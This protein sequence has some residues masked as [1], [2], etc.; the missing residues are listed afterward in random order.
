[1]SILQKSLPEYGHRYVVFRFL[2]QDENQEEFFHA[3][4][5][6]S[7]PFFDSDGLRRP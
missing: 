5:I 1:M 7:S 6:R 4:F 2:A 3:D